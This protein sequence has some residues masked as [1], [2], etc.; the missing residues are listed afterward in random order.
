M[1]QISQVAVFSLASWPEWASTKL[2]S[3]SLIGVWL[4]TGTPSCWAAH[5]SQ[6]CF[7][8]FFPFLISVRWTVAVFLQLSHFIGVTSLHYAALPGQSYFA[9]PCWSIDQNGLS[10]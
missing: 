1:P 6:R 9:H 7:S 5:C 2:V 10:L 3:S 4:L 8:S